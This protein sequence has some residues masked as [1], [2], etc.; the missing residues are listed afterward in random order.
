[1]STLLGETG[2]A[3]R[4]IQNLASGIGQAIEG[5]TERATNTVLKTAPAI[6]PWTGGRRAAAD[7]LHGKDPLK[8]VTVRLW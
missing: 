6:G 5:D 8:D 2:P 3:A 4:N 7:V 1:M